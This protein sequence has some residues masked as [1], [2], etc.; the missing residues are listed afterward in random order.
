MLCSENKEIEVIGTKDVPTQQE[1]GIPTE[2]DS[3][4]PLWCLHY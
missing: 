1:A 2:S 3:V 4:C